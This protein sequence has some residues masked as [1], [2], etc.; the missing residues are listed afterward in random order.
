MLTCPNCDSIEVTVAHLQTF[1]ANTGEHYCH[2]IKTQD[3]ESPSTC[4]DC[5]WEGERKHLGGQSDETD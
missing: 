5:G 3:S 4:L 1:M 2:S